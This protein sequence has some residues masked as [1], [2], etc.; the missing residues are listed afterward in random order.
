M[1]CMTRFPRPRP[2]EFGRGKE[3]EEKRQ[4]RFSRI[5]R[6]HC[7]QPLGRGFDEDLISEPPASSSSLSSQR[8]ARHLPTYLLGGRVVGASPHHRQKLPLGA[9]SRRGER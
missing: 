4:S 9:G 6:G 2:G 8:A 5:R 7:G 1:V 3:M